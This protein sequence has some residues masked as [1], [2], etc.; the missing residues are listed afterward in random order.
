MTAHSDHKGAFERIKEI[1]SYVP[2][3]PGT[4]VP[5]RYKSSLGAISMEIMYDIEFLLR[6]FEVMR[7]IAI[8]GIPDYKVGILGSLVEMEFEK[9]MSK[10]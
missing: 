1:K 6:A 10:E 3:I 2:A 9:R 8:E 5:P 7:E 4:D